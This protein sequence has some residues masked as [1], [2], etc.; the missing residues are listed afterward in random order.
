MS[1]GFDNNAGYGFGGETQHQAMIH[2]A[3]QNKDRS[4]T[5]FVFMPKTQAIEDMAVRPFIYNFDENLV[6][7]AKEAAEL[8]MQ[9]KASGQQMLDEL[10]EGFNFSDSMIV[11]PQAQGIIRTSLLS[12]SHRFMLLVTDSMSSRLVGDHTLAHTGS[13]FLRWIYTGYFVDEPFHTSTWGRDPVPNPNARMIITHKTK[14]NVLATMGQT[15]TNHQLNTASSCDIL[16]PTTTVN[17]SAAGPD[18][19]IHLMTPEYCSMATDMTPDGDIRIQMPGNK[20]DITEDQGS[21]YLHDFLFQP[22]RNVNHVLGGIIKHQDQSVIAA[23]SPGRR[24]SADLDDIFSNQAFSRNRLSQ[25][26]SIHQPNVKADFDL[27]INSNITPID[28]DRMLNG[29]LRVEHMDLER[30]MFHD[31]MDQTAVNPTTQFSALIAEVVPSVLQSVGFQDMIFEFQIAEIRGELR[32]Q[33]IIHHASPVW[34]VADMAEL[35]LMKRTVEDIV[36]NG[37]MRTIYTSAG[38]FHVHVSVD[39]IGMTR[40][41]LSLV[42]QGLQATNNYE[43]PTLLGGLISPL[44]GSRPV[45]DNNAAAIGD[46]SAMMTGGVKDD[47]SV[48]FE[49]MVQGMNLR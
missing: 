45:F 28:L 11:T 12:E 29:Q 1:F 43:K 26:L 4:G 9:G 33:F 3:F 13:G 20:S 6:G 47:D 44:I 5:L 36:A 34:P 14:L 19:R 49:R 23:R 37:I 17:L 48:M 41:R 42:G 15:G 40:V 35:N 21:Q 39:T 46:L 2:S 7:A 8:S 38:D 30:P 32:P 16:H 27:D 18:Q 31:T 22:H 10:H 25:H 24:P